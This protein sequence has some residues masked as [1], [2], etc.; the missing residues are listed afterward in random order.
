MA[1]IS[2]DGIG[3]VMGGVGF[4]VPVEPF[5]QADENRIPT[6]KDVRKNLFKLVL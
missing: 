5:E 1:L 6:I 2:Q 3:C 4:V